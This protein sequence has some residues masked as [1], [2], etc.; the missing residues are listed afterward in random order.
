[1]QL[2]PDKDRTLLFHR[3]VTRR[4]I[5]MLVAKIFE[6]DKTPGN[7][8]LIINSSGGGTESAITFY[9][10]AKKMLT[11]PLIT[12]AVGEV[13]S[14][15]TI[16]F[17]AGCK[18]YVTPSATFYLHVGKTSSSEDG[19]HLSELNTWSESH[20]KQMNTFYRIYI[21]NSNL[22]KRRINKMVNKSVCLSA[23]EM[24]KFGFAQELTNE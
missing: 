18:R 6:L 5:R 24:L 13:G 14:S 12:I 22:S 10:I 17:L 1:M 9:E 2:V 15:A 21:Q 20:K 11:N 4:S 8:Y 23:A 3:E 16:M 7:I 19:V